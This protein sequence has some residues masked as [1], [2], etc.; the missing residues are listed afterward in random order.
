M[1]TSSIVQWLDAAGRHKAED[2]QATI[3][4]IRKMR[5][6]DPSSK[7]YL[8]LLNKV[9][10]M[11][12]LLVG[13]VVRKFVE[14]RMVIEWRDGNVEDLL[15][16][17]YFGLRRAVEKFDPTRGYR[18][19]T[20][21]TPWIRQAVSRLSHQLD[22]VCHIP[23]GVS[24]QL[25]HIRR[26]GKKNTTAASLSKNDS[27]I[28][29]AQ[30]VQSPV[31]LDAVIRDSEGG[32]TPFHERVVYSTPDPTPDHQT[33][34]TWA[35]TMLEQKIKAA[36]LTGQEAAMIRAYSHRGRLVSAAS[37][38]GLGEKTGRPILQ[39]AMTKLQ[40]LAASEA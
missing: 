29:A 39:S 30:F 4:I 32:G 8:R 26:T 6:L 34:V 1:Q 36:G 33:E 23:E 9:C 25:M 13:Q 37:K 15:Q 20:Y 22:N 24:Q 35:T 18:F 2:R 10:E 3:D 17:G 12:L 38:L 21:A 31:R 7:Q 5:T 19:S 28:Q 11:N 14:K 40:A 16:Q 27:L